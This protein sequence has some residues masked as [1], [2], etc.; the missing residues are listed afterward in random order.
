[1]PVT[2]DELL[3]RLVDLGITATTHE[4]PPLRTVDE[5][6]RLRGEL[7]GAHV[8]NLF[9]RGKQG[10]YWLFTTLEDKT[11]DLKALGQKLDAGRFSFGS[12][13]ALQAMLG[14]LPGAV[15]P[16]AAINDPIGAVTVVLDEALLD[17]ELLN[18]H[19][20]R[21][22]RTTALA[23]RDLVRFLD[24]CGHPPHLIRLQAA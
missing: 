10:R 21:N 4:H 7:P 20:L 1:M 15:S 17:A 6:K 16:L 12:A 5:A 22:D 19:P 9:L 8:K 23:P 14:I 24:A 13:D 2:P 3:G 18:V 11:V